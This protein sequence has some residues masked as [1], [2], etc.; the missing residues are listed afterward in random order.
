MLCKFSFVAAPT[1]LESPVGLEVWFDHKVIVDDDK[2]IKS[3]TV[4]INF[5]D[6]NESAH[7]LKIILKN[8]TTQ[9]T[10]INEHGEIVSDSLI[11]ISDIKLDDIDIKKVFLDKSWYYHAFNSDAEPIKDYFFGDMGCNGNVEFVFTSPAYIWLLE[12]L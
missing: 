1:N 12:N 7:F 11:T 8:K 4:D 2:F 9:H 6:D 5:D 3:S 10:K